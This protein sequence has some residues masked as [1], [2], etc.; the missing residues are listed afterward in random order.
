[1]QQGT[2]ASKITKATANKRKG[3]PGGKAHA[4]GKAKTKRKQDEDEDG[5]ENESANNSPASPSRPQ[6]RRGIEYF[7]A[8]DAEDL[9]DSDYV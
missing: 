6:K 5:N 1:L 4:N 8:A 7:G 2:T 3:A 9:A